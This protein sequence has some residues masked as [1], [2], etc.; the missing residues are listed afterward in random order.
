MQLFSSITKSRDLSANPDF[1]FAIKSQLCNSYPMSKIL[2]AVLEPK[3]N[4][5]WVIETNNKFYSSK[6]YLDRY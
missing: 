2:R 5:N 3:P 1:N 4:P 6:V